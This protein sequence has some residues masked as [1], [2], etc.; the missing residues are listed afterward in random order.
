M[1]FE[2]EDLRVD[3]R[4]VAEKESWLACATGAGF[5]GLA[6]APSRTARALNL[7]CVGDFFSVVTDA[8][9]LCFARHFTAQPDPPSTL[10]LKR[11]VCDRSGHPRRFGVFNRSMSPAMSCAGLSPLLTSSRSCFIDKHFL[12]FRMF[13]PGLVTKEIWAD[14]FANAHPHD[15]DQA[16]IGSSSQHSLQGGSGCLFFCPWI[17]PIVP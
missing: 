8:V 11:A 7:R 15:V 4:S 13:R 10:F 17:S 16:D 9:L 2:C 12:H 3:G 14:F 6:S 1:Q 5:L